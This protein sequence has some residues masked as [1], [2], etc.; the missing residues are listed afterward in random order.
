LLFYFDIKFPAALFRR[1]R[2]I[3]KYIELFSAGHP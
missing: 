2:N 1:P 3:K